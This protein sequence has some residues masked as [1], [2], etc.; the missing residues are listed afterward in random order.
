MSESVKFDSIAEAVAKYVELRDQLAEERQSFEAYEAS[1][2]DSMEK[3][4]MWLRDKGDELS[5]DSFATPSGTAYRNTKTYYRLDGENAWEQFTKWI[6]ETGNFQC[7][8][9]RVAKLATAEILEET[10]ELPPG[11]VKHTEV[12]F[13]VRRPTKGKSK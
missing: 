6:H 7:L 13:N 12:E 11:I 3:I 5:V 1:V 8:E 4:S 2:K 10:G 9:K